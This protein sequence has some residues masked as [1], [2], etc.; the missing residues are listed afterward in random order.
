VQEALNNVA[1]HAKATE[2]RVRF[3]RTPE[4]LR[5]AVEDN[6]GGFDP[7]A[8]RTADR[9]GLGLIG[10]RERASYLKG[11][12]TIDSAPGQ[13]TRL[14]VELPARRATDSGVRAYSPDAAA[15]TG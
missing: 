7:A 8:V 5:V 10:I 1:K 14:V 9:R 3:S 15:L 12:V 2:C 13:G 4:L 6:G 11:S